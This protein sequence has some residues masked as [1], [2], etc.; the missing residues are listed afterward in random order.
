MRSLNEDN[1]QISLELYGTEF[2]LLR[3][4]T[5]SDQNLCSIARSI[6]SSQ[7][8]FVEEVI[9]TEREVC[10]KLNSNFSY[11]DLVKLGE[12]NLA[13][14][15]SS[16]TWKIP[17][18]FTDHPDWNRVC[19]HCLISRELYIER[20]CQTELEVRMFG[21]LP[22]FVYISELPVDMR[23]PRKE[24]PDKH[25]KANAFAV[26]EQYAGIYSYPSPGGWNVL[27]EIAC[28]VANIP[29]LPPVHLDIHDKI[30]IVRISLE[31]MQNIISQGSN[32]LDY[33]GF[34]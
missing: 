32:I 30:Q 34:S 28:P 8:E 20:L 9:G 5:D 7:F 24:V 22:G 26:A 6:Y 12:F 15:S 23:C 4:V 27:G 18:W 11:S 16:R 19:D 13:D 2:I 3:S 1:S 14:L 21:F 33:N 10:I 17:V 31:E 25:I 29:D